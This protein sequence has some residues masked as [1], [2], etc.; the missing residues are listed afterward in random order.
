MLLACIFVMA[1]QTNLEWGPEPRPPNLPAHV[2]QLRI[3]VSSI[4]DP[5][6]FGVTTH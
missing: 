3:Q 2:E 4:D 5:L 6:F 1:E